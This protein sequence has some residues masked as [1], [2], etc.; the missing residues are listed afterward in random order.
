MMKKI[1]I[2]LLCVFVA[3]VKTEPVN[4]EKPIEDG[5]S[6]APEIDA[7]ARD[8]NSKD[9]ETRRAAVASL[10]KMVI[11]KQG[12]DMAAFLPVVEPLMTL[13][14]WGGIARKQSTTA[15]D[16]LAVI[17]KP[18]VP[19][20]LAGLSSPEARERRVS[21]RILT[22]M[23]P[24][25]PGLTGALSPLISDN[26]RFVRW[27][28]YDCL[29]RLGKD[30]QEAVP[31]LKAALVHLPP[32][33][34]IYGRLALIQITGKTKPHVA[35]IAAL[36]RHN[37][38]SVRRLAASKLGDIGPPAKDSWKGLLRGL[39]DS[40]RSVRGASAFSLGAIGADSKKVVT[41]LLRILENDE[42]YEIR[43]SAASSLGKLGANARAA[44]PALARALD[45]SAEDRSPN[46]ERTGWAVAARAVGEIGGPS[47]VPVL[48]K[49]LANADPYIRGTAARQL[50]ALEA[51]ASPALPA[52]QKAAKDPFVGR[53]ALEAIQKIEEA[54]ALSTE[55]Q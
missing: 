40:D 31:L 26:D 13:S 48:V 44:I 49:A 4:A 8:I 47:A 12:D 22:A 20:L 55:R 34:N 16:I 10:H 43:R 2:L 18:A 53:L 52:L 46:R 36:L 35:R 32:E 50:G 45:N 54:L 24:R 33:S 51:L 23:R 37:D 3:I 30:A 7:L 29:G 9:W 25:P 28:C 19:R 1:A 38:A 27:A 21:A 17:G 41:A 5:G 42:E 6:R 14:G 39:A 11:E 15:A